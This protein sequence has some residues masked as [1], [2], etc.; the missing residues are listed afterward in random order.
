MR[1]RRYKRGNPNCRG[2]EQKPKPGSPLKRI[3]IT[4]SAAETAV[5]LTASSDRTP[6]PTSTTRR[7]DHHPATRQR[8]TDIERLPTR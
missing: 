7:A 4:E 6:H 8:R 2:L 1:S 3:S 5:K